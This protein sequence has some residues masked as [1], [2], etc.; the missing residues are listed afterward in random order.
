MG[1]SAASLSDVVAAAD[2]AVHE[3][4]IAVESSSSKRA[5]RRARR[6]AFEAEIARTLLQRAEGFR[7]EAADLLAILERAAARLGPDD[8][9]AAP[10]QG[11]PFARRSTDPGGAERLKGAP[12]STWRG[13]ERRRASSD[14]KMPDGATGNG[15]PMAN[16]G[17]S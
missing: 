1:R 2:R 10:A 9:S 7:A 13:P 16:E 6:R 11:V 14:E 5:G 4:Q 15:K 3:L 8:A 17:A 12:P